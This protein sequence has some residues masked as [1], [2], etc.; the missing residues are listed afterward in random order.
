MICSKI[1]L[2]FDRVSTTDFLTITMWNFVRVPGFNIA[3]SFHER[4]FTF[5]TSVF[6]N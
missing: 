4:D 2:K 6:V 3:A 5:T 1:S